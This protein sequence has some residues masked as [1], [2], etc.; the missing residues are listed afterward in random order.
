MTATEPFSEFGDLDPANQKWCKNAPPQL[1]EQLRGTAPT[2]GMKK[3]VAMLQS[4]P[5]AEAPTAGADEPMLK[6][7]MDFYH[8]GARRS[9]RVRG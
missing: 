8:V 6:K 3:L 4:A 2:A 1:Q 5:P 7:K 9:A